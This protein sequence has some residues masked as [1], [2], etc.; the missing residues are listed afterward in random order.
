MRAL[1]SVDCR[2]AGTSP[3]P[4]KQAIKGVEEEEEV[5]LGRG[6]GRMLHLGRVKRK[7]KKKKK[8]IYIVGPAPTLRVKKD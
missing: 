5:L 2:I 4:A 6:R 8:K 1:V 7:K 3:V